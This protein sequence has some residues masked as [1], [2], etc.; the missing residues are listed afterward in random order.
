M[1]QYFC[2]SV[3]DVCWWLTSQAT[4]LPYFRRMLS[5]RE[6][7]RRSRRRKLEHVHIIT[8]QVRGQPVGSQRSAGTRRAPLDVLNAIV[9]EGGDC[10]EYVA[11]LPR[12]SCAQLDLLRQDTSTVGKQLADSN[13]RNDVLARENAALKAEVERLNAQVGEEAAFCARTASRRHSS[14]LRTYRLHASDP[15]PCLPLDG[16]QIRELAGGGVGIP[17]VGSMQ[18]IPSS[19]HLVKRLR[20]CACVSW[21]TFSR[22]S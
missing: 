8:G 13:A 20:G 12:F 17:R 14:P 19:D 5:N 10:A 1:S 18:R 2:P 22:I 9:F 16:T 3:D 21:P 11:S 6:S 4:P 7:A 15:K